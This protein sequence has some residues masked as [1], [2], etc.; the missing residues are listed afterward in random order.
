[1]GE[2]CNGLVSLFI[3]CSEKYGKEEIKNINYNANDRG[4]E[5]ENDKQYSMCYNK[6]NPNL[7]KYCGPDWVF[8]HWPSANIL[9]FEETKNNIMLE[10]NKNP[11]PSIEKVGWFGNIYSPLN[12]VIEYKTRPL[13]KKIGDEN[14]E[15]FDIVHISP[16]HGIINNNIPNYLS[17][18]DL[19]KYKYLIDIGGNGY[20][21]RLKL[22]LFSKR[23]LLLVDRDYVEYFHDDLIPYIH[24]IPVKNDLSDLL[25]QINWMKL[26]PEKSLEI[27]DN[28]FNYAINNF[29]IDNLLDRIF[30]VYNNLL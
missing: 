6:N 30:I 14:P 19:I 23:P 24:Y 1:M 13:L 16:I 28:A 3:K 9:H 8:Y 7:K 2:R 4:N 10:Y 27:A 21:G 26:N 11:I 17:L 12:D 5:N 15:L 22:L 20:S 25:E 29:N 18:P